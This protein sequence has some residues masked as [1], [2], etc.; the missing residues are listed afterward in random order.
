VFSG[1]AVAFEGEVSMKRLACLLAWVLTAAVHAQAQPQPTPP[2]GP[3]PT[4]IVVGNGNF[5][6]PIVANLDKA[7]AFY[8]DGLGF[9]ATGEPGGA[10]KG[11]PL[12]DM[13]GLPDATLR[14]MV[15]R[16]PGITGGV[17]MVEISNANGKPVAR[18]MQDPG[19]FTL[20]VLVRDIDK[21]VAGLKKVGAPV[22]TIGGEPALVP[23]GPGTQA[24]LLMTRD[25]DGHF[26]EVV[27]PPEFA[28]TAPAGNIVEVRVRL[29]VAD[30]PTAVKL[31][32]DTLGLELVNQSQFNDNPAV[33]SAFGLPGMQFR[34]GMLKVPTT[35]LTFEVID[36][37]GVESKAVRGNLQDPGSTRIQMRV[38]DVDEA[39]AALTKAGGQVVS[40][41]GKPLVIPAG[42]GQLKV[43]IVREPDNLFLVLIGPAPAQAAA[44]R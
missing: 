8:R 43:A 42:Q 10:T 36:F 12:L 30:V 19:A 3:A 13:F 14:W 5:F 11:A 35:G 7:V 18:N 28:A 37:K 22:L 26:V 16:A 15:G 6:S 31:Y 33:A 24:K 1:Y 34:F 41:G 39:V 17:E 9:E 20:L 29:T 32:H 44:T 21:V 25:P 2:A 38:R 40:T 27:Q 4:G 23:M